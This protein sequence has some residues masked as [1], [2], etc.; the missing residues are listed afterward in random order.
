VLLLASDLPFIGGA[1]ASLSEPT[2]DVAILVDPDGRPNYLASVWRR[3]IA[4]S[5]LQRIGDPTGLSMR[6]LLDD[7]TVAKVRDTG[8]WGFDCDTWDA[9]EQARQRGARDD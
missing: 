6:R 5:A 8:G 4:E 3:D 1:I 2:A 9:V 7:L